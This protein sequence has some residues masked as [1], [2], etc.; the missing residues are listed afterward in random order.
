MLDLAL[1][2]TIAERQRHD[3]SS[4]P[5]NKSSSSSSASK[6]LPKPG[7]GAG[8]A[9]HQLQS[10]PAPLSSKEALT[11]IKGQIDYWEVLLKVSE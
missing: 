6:T 7:G 10:P 11:N 3:G 2:P 5:R 4:P 1:D 9:Q 8:D